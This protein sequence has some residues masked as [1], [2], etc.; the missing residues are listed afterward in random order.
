MSSYWPFLYGHLSN[1]DT[2][3]FP[4]SVSLLERCDCISILL[5]SNTILVV[6]KFSYNIGYQWLPSEGLLKPSKIYWEKR[7]YKF[8]RNSF[9]FLNMVPVQYMENVIKHVVY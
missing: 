4:I 1:T 2:L 6:V 9:V 3:L 7:F 8:H 5:I